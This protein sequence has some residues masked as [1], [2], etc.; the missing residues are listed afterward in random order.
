MRVRLLD[1]QYMTRI[2]ILV[3]VAIAVVAVAVAAAAA[4]AIVVVLLLLF[5]CCFCCCL[6]FLVEAS[7]QVMVRKFKHFLVSLWKE[8]NDRLCYAN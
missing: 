1:I 8:A 7:K 4:A 3:I 5:C 2:F 6:E